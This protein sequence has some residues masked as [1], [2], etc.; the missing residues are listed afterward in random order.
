MDS[1]DAT[2]GAVLVLDEDGR[3]ADVNDRIRDVFGYEPT[4]LVGEPIDVLVADGGPTSGTELRRMATAHG[5]TIDV[6]ESEA[7]GLRLEFGDA[8]LVDAADADIGDCE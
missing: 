7:G 4:D 1:V 6:T 5:W 3:I 8:D 2:S